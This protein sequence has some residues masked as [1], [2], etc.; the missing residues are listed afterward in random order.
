MVGNVNEAYLLTVL[1]DQTISNEELERF[2]RLNTGTRERTKINSAYEQLNEI[3][4]Y[5]CSR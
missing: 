4:L 5:S 2:E 3:E 1:N